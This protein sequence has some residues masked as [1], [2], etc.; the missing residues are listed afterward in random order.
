MERITKRIPLQETR[1]ALLAWYY[2]SRR[3][4]PWRKTDDPYRIWVSEVM[5]QQ[6][7]VATVI[8]YYDAFTRKFPTVEALAG[9]ELE[10][11]LKAWE[12]L[13]YYARARNLYR[14]AGKI[15]AEHGGQIPSK[16]EKLAA[17]PGI[18]KYTAAALLSIAFGRPL[19]VVDGNVKRVLSRLFLM[20]TPVNEASSDPRFHKRAECLLDPKRPGDFNQALME[21]GAR[22]CRPKN[23]EC[24]GCPV[25][26]S[27]RA[28]AKKKVD[29]YPKRRLR[30]K[31]PLYA[32]AIGVIF[33]RGRVLIIRRKEEGL[34][35][36]LWEFPGGK[37]RPGES[38]RQACAREIRE[39]VR[40]EVAVG[41]RLTRVRHGYT[42]FKIV[43][44][45]F[46]CRHRF[47]R[48]LRADST[49][50]RWV[51]I[52]DLHRYPFPGANRKFIP[53]L[54]SIRLDEKET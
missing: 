32:V 46:I 33:R 45:I 29:Q 54:S 21:L 23:P 50:H 24:P 11:V 37:I 44:E 51:R 9:S 52:A 2:G 5:L 40:L 34:L 30:P 36:G 16:P 49:A 41:N 20:D 47:G 17:L 22:I 6:T 15:V 18:G 25:S 3:D 42:H 28:L 35:G 48:V 38:P 10:E 14:A 13:G 12:G 26:P 53:M 43:A 19:A 4:L 31:V 7:Q 27:C 39:E 8:P 1:S